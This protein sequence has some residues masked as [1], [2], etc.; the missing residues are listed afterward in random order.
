MGAPQLRPMYSLA[1]MA[2][3]RPATKSARPMPWRQALSVIV[4]FLNAPARMRK[5]ATMTM[6][7]R[8]PANWPHLLRPCL[9]PAARANQ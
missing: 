8:K 7:M 5:R 2:K 1:Q 6:T 4:S 9:L 3:P